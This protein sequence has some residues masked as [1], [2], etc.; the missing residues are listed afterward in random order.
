MSRTRAG[1][2]GAVFMLA[3][4]ALTI[5]IGVAAYAAID[6]NRAMVLAGSAARE[7]LAVLLNN[8]LDEETGV[9]GYLATRNRLFLAPY[10]AAQRDYPQRYAR[11]LRDLRA[12]M[13]AQTRAE[14]AGFDALHARW[15]RDT[16]A[17]LLASR[18]RGVT[19]ALELRGKAQVD[20]MRA[21]AAAVGRT[22]DRVNRRERRFTT[23]VI[24]GT[25]GGI[26]LLTALFGSLALRAE[27][28]RAEQERAL[29]TEIAERNDALEQS[30]R[31]LEE[32]AYVASHDLQEPLRTV[33]SFAGL[34]QQRY[35]GRLDAEADEFLHYIV[36]GATRMR[37]LIADVL[38]YSRVTTQ[39]APLEP[40]PLQ[41]VLDR[42]RAALRVSLDERGAVISSDSLPTVLGDERQLEQVFQN[43]IGNALKYHRGE[44][45]RIEILA[46][47]GSDGIVTIGVRDDGIGIAPEHHDAV[48]GIFSRLHSRGEYAGN[49]I[50][51]AICKRVIERHGGRIRLES[52]PGRGT[53]VYFTLSS[54]EERS[55][56]A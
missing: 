21:R 31:A 8:V 43:L 53:T 37:A 28:R 2:R 55:G 56:A 18:G 20:A 11:L 6:S 29:R 46:S 52:E 32:F 1:S 38:E 34:L 25:I 14:L 36:D 15:E 33:A 9:R 42:T 54:A 48:F 13:Y 39:G 10:D 7:E 30:N 47:S 16:L 44:H 26:V 4:M 5:A 51:L 12:P 27:S 24:G 35:L 19:L 49:G 45:P 17:P 41:R 50:G 40:V 3:L 23:A 22:L